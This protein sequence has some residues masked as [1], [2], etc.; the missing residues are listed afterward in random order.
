MVSKYFS[1]S[2]LEFNGKNYHSWAIKI[3]AY[4][5]AMSLRDV[6]EKDENPTLP[7]NPTIAQIKDFDKQMTKRPRTLACLLSG[8]LEEI[9]TTIMDCESPKETLEKLM[10]EFEGNAQTKLMQIFNLKRE[11]EEWG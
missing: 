4:L 1:F 11:F 2:I 9:F 6:I 3:K 5:R 8:V 10:K 7:H